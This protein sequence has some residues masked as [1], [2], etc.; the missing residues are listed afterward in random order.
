MFYHVI[1][2][3]WNQVVLTPKTSVYL[4]RE[5]GKDAVHGPNVD[6]VLK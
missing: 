5:M 6:V 2:Y 3:Q 1:R 4:Q